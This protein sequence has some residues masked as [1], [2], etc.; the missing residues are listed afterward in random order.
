MNFTNEEG[1]INEPDEMHIVVRPVSTS[2]TNED[3]LTIKNLIKDPIKNPLDITNS[4][5][6]SNKIIDINR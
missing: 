5:D 2:P 1:I 3:P 6:L 4:I